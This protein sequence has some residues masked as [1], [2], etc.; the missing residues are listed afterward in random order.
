MSMIPFLI[1]IMQ[2]PSK[3]ETLPLRLHFNFAKPPL[4]CPDGMR[5]N[6]ELRVQHD[7]IRETARV[8][9]LAHPL[10]SLLTP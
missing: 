2:R 4:L 5:A 3:M 7:V 1:V 6:T 9:N 8:R 10:R